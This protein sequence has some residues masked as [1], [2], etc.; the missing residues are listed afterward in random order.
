[1]SVLSSGPVD[2]ENAA[3]DQTTRR[4][5]RWRRWWAN[6]VARSLSLLGLVVLLVM[7]TITLLLASAR[8]QQADDPR[9][10]IPTGAAAL[11]QLLQ[12]SGVDL[13][14][15]NRLSEAVQDSDARTTLVVANPDR[16]SE[17][18]AQ[19][20]LTTGAARLVLLGPST[21]ALARFGL[22][23][24]TVEPGAGA[25]TPQCPDSSAQRAGSIVD[26]DL[27]FSYLAPAGA[28]LA[29][30]PSGAGFVQLRVRSGGV[31]VDLVAGGLANESLAR[32]GNA[33]FATALL[34]SQP[35]LVWLMAQTPTADTT[36]HTPTLLPRWW[37]IAL[38]QGFLAVIALGVWQGRRLGPI[39]VE[40][41]PVTVRASETVEGHGRLYYRL[42]ARDRA[43]EALRAAARD[44]LGRAFGHRSAGAAFAP[45]EDREGLA[46]VVANRTGADVRSVY[47]LL[48]G[49]P[50]DTD[51]H[52]RD[53]ALG[54]DQLEQEASRL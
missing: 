29:C 4:P 24:T 27:R 11:A 42:G 18:Q 12:D 19:Q 30:Y 7:F 28:E 49:R 16:L 10:T 3:G 13:T 25:L 47:D 23:A 53:L 44:R 37:Q 22:N 15:T 6:R 52:L 41:L 14:T 36:D 26:D 31:P 20:L 43:A 35:R 9:S 51:D 2:A 48:Y 54:L 5:S 34:G 32:E 50:P 39:L 21:T 46:T 1:M 40:A 38:V 45:G 17:S 33:S 8:S